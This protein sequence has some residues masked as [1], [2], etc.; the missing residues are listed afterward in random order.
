[1]ELIQTFQYKH[2]LLKEKQNEIKKKL[3]IMQ[4]NEE[5]NNIVKYLTNS[6]NQRIEN[7][8]SLNQILQSKLS[9]LSSKNSNLINEKNNNKNNNKNEKLNKLKEE[10]NLLLKK[11]SDN[12]NNIV[13]SIKSIEILERKYSSVQSKSE[14]DFAQFDKQIEEEKLFL[15]KET[16]GAGQLTSFLETTHK[17]IVNN[18]TEVA[19]RIAIQLE[20]I[21]PL[22]I[23]SIKSYL[24][25]HLQIIFYILESKITEKQTLNQ[26]N[27]YLLDSEPL[28]HNLKQ[29]LLD[30]TLL[31]PSDIHSNVSY[32]P[33]D[34]GLLFIFIYFFVI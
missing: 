28:L 13:Y 8:S 19:S 15:S 27:G 31:A 14:I 21:T 2:K 11:I 3:K 9:Q 24:E 22:Y 1:M 18:I 5:I 17:N 30:F 32:V 12:K 23:S 25:L 7:L 16:F 29:V 33:Y 10:R 34:D 4:N 6:K 26:I 20:E